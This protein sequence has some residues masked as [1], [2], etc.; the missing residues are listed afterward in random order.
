MGRWYG[1][2]LGLY[3]VKVLYDRFLSLDRLSSVLSLL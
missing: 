2:V 3:E 1:V